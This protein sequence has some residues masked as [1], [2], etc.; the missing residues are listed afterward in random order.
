MSRLSS[1]M[2]EISEGRSARID[3]ARGRCYNA[4]HV[5][6]GNTGLKYS[7]NQDDIRQ[8]FT[9]YQKDEETGLDFAVAQMLHKMEKGRRDGSPR[10]LKYWWPGTG[11]NR[12]H[13]D[14]QSAA[15]PTELPG[16]NRVFRRR[17]P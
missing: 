13:A 7:S 10:L 15:L 5:R 12:R 1:S 4:V 17:N 9:G 8:K 16:R 11:S 6:T 14:F 2:L 3:V